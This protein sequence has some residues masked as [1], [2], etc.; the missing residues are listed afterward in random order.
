METMTE[1]PLR[2]GVLRLLET[3]RNE[4][5]TFDRALT[6]AERERTGDES[7]PEIK[8]LVARATAGRRSATRELQQ[9]LAGEQADGCDDPVADPTGTWAGIQRD[10]HATTSAL[11]AA[12]EQVSE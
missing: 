10:A 11:V 2:D 1:T 8:E 7:A 12:L 4:E 5:W 3:E 9:V 6:T